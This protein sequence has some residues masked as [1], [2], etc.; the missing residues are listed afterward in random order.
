MINVCMKNLAIQ[1]TFLSFIS[2]LFLSF[3]P[4]KE[5]P[6]D[7]L[8]VE[9]PLSFGKINFNL[10]WTDHPKDSY[11]V[12]EYLPEGEK[13][14]NF[15]QMLTINLFVT[16]LAVKDAVAQKTK[17]L[18]K[19]KEIDGMCDYQVNE[20]PDGKEFILDFLLGES[21]ENKMTIAEFNVYR[22]KQIDVDGGK[23]A[24]IVYAYSKRAYA[25][26]ITSFLKSLVNE[27]VEYL[28]YMISSEIPDIK[29]SK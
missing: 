25:N 9:G 7:W 17:E 21:K 3:A 11:Y 15:K 27:R 1:K 29:I 13:L 12:Q 4:A 28:N 23:K 24:I 22:Y 18:T 26:D 10:A 2:I 20:S 8:N 6:Q 19:R 16:D 5:D 14:S